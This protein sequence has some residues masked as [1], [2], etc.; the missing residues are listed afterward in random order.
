MKVSAD[1]CTHRTPISTE[2]AAAHTHHFDA[3]A[4]RA[5]VSGRQRYSGCMRALLSFE[6]TS[7]PRGSMAS[8][9]SVYTSRTEINCYLTRYPSEFI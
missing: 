4:T 8:W 3:R 5:F 7:V 6:Y 1:L 9:G 2:Q